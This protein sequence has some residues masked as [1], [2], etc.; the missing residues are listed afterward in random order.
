V[1][2]TTG[3]PRDLD[4]ESLRRVAR[5]FY[6]VK[7]VRH[8]LLLVSTLGIGAAGAASGAP[9]AVPVTLAVLATVFASLMVLTAVYYRRQAGSSP[10]S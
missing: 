10:R 9:V 1:V 6:I 4:D 2:V 8:A 3:S 5:S 7:M